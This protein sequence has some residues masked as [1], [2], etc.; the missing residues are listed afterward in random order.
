M[1]FDDCE[2]L[3]IAAEA[4]WDAL[5]SSMSSDWIMS[6]SAEKLS[7]MERLLGYHPSKAA[8]MSH[9]Q[10]EEETLRWAVD[11]HV[12]WAGEDDNDDD[13]S[14]RVQP[15][16]LKRLAKYD[17]IKDLRI[18]SSCETTLESVA[19][20]WS[21]IANALEEQR[22]ANNADSSSVHFIV[23]PKSKSLWN[24]DTMVTF[25]RAIQ[26]SKPFL[27]PEYH[28]QFDL[29]HPHYKHSPRMWSPELHAPFPTIGISIREKLT[30]SME[31]ID[32]DATRAKL[33]ALF[34]SMDANPEYITAK[35][36]DEEGYA[37]ILQKCMAWIQ[38]K[39][40]SNT[41][42]IDDLEWTIQTHE[43]PFQLYKTLWN[44]ILTL[45]P[46]KTS[47]MVVVPSLD[48]HTLYRVAVTVN[49]ALIRLHIPVRITQVYTPY[50]TSKGKSQQRGPPPPYGMIQL[51]SM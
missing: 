21:V 3:G 38:S 42:D 12:V 20:V 2:R 29:F 17:S 37:Q 32:V 26:V 51:T 36:D 11:T 9:E 50:Q 8:K 5:G 43:G 39:A 18:A 30:Q 24:Y 45:T 14:N 25:L 34:Q 15:E 1:Y 27:P 44:T 6:Q 41:A 49:V 23:F 28:V 22:K 13:E 47:S 33:D 10:I 19:F 16:G 31:E 4:S 48:S 46:H 40:N 7:A 35:P